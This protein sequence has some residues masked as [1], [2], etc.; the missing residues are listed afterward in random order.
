MYIVSAK[1][2]N[3]FV[4]SDTLQQNKSGPRPKKIGTTGVTQQKYGL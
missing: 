4:A 2:K 3:F 1:F